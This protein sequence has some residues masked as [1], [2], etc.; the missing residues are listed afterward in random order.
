MLAGDPGGIGL[1]GLQ[2][3]HQH[4][5]VRCQQVFASD[6]QDHTLPD[7]VALAVVF[8]QAEVLVAAVGGFD[9]TEEQGLLLLHHKY[10][11]E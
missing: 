7:L 1:L 4:V 11:I 10:S 3:A 6:V 9:R 5:Q 8:D 2:Q